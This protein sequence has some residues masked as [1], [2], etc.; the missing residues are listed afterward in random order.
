[1]LAVAGKF[2][3]ARIATTVITGYEARFA[4]EPGLRDA[5]LRLLA[6]RRDWVNLLLAE[7]AAGRIRPREFSDDVVQQLEAYPDLVVA[8]AVRKH[9]ANLRPR[10]SSAEKVA[11]A[12]RIKAVL[13]GGVGRGDGV[14][15]KALF[16]QR[17]AA[18]HGLFDA[19]GTIGPNLTGYERG[20]AD[21][22]LAGVLDPS[23]EIR[24]GYGAYTA[25][26]Q[27]GQTLMGQLTRQDA[28][29]SVLRDLAGQLHTLKTAEV[30]SLTA[31][32][33]SLMPEGLLAGLDDAAL[34]DLFSYLMKP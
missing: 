23:I 9:W 34:R 14:K 10:L 2:D 4:G 33:V 8:A 11:E 24:E 28:T 19:G 32:P 15:G 20:N 17:C 22:W 13:G 31:L 21:F 12:A 26:L 1:M 30:A 27:N 18:C 3:D 25:T 29:G 16:A 6:S 7:I 5:A